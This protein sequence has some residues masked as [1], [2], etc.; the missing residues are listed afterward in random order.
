MNSNAQKRLRTIRLIIWD[1]DET[2]YFSKRAIGVVRNA[3]L[4]EF[5]AFSRSSK[6]VNVFYQK[7]KSGE[8]WFE[9]VAEAKGLSPKQ[10]ILAID[11][12]IPRANHIY[13]NE[14]LVQFF[15]TSR[16]RH[17]LITNSTAFSVDA[18]MNRLGLSDYRQRFEHIYTIETM[19]KPKPNKT[20]IQT[21]A[22][23]TKIKPEYILAIGNSYQEDLQCPHIMGMMTCLIDQKEK[24]TSADITVKTLHAI[25]AYLKKYL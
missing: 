14:A 7:E 3:Y 15:S 1:L 8:R 9:I 21:I 22:A 13:R 2:L 20:I 10:A 19:S 11:P 17:L 4:K 12:S 6:S 23:K 5:L 16:L 18:I 25:L 24:Q